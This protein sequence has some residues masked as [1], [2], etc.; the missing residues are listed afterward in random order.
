M[1]TGTQ[2]DNCSYGPLEK[3]TKDDCQT[4]KMF[5]EFAKSMGMEEKPENKGQKK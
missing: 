5:M 2:C 1:P 4:K 3:C